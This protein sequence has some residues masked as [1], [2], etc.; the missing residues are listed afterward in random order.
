MF[1]LVTQVALMRG[2]VRRW[3]NKVNKL[4]EEGWEPQSVSI[5]K[6][7]LKMICIAL[8]KKSD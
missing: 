3:E 8:L 7:G 5:D 1:K 6:K 4:M 2:G